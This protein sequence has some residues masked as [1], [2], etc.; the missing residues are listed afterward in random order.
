[1]QKNRIEQIRSYISENKL[2]SIILNSSKSLRYFFGFTGSSGLGL[3][4]GKTV[5]FITDFRYRSQTFSEVT[6]DEI[7]IVDTPLFDNLA[8]IEAFQAPSG[9]RVGFEAEYISY[10]DYCSLNNYSFHELL[11]CEEVTAGITSIKSDFE[12]EQIRKACEVTVL[13]YNEIINCFKENVSELDIAAEISYRIKKSGGEGDAFNPHVLFGAH[14]AFPHGTSK[15]NKL[16]PGDLIQLDFGAVYNGYH[17]DFSRVLLFGKPG[18]EQKEL[19]LA[20]RDAIE[21]AIACIKP[22]VPAQKIDKTARNR[23]ERRGFDLYF[24]HASGHG[25]GL[26][27]HEL[28][29]I[30]LKNED[31]VRAGNV[32]TIEPGVYIPGLGG[33]RIEDVVSVGTSDISILTD[34][35]RDLV[36]L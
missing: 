2:D 7:V 20:V 21:H 9:M 16:Q 5:F 32:F 26:E 25:V 33:V 34:T 22:G 30:S 13:V 36:L 28:P 8:S 19:Y 10:H 17:S 11:P 23:I 4:T 12:V 1:M 29:R 14:T 15:N 31:P 6:A 18:R 3:I 24:K 27:I 35:S